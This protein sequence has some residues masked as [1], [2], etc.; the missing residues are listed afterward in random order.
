MDFEKMRGR[1]N[2]KYPGY[3]A[4]VNASI[5][6]KRRQLQEFNTDVHW[7][8]A[9]G[10]YNVTTRTMGAM[11]CRIVSK[12]VLDVNDGHAFIRVAN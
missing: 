7:V 2:A 12:N 10:G 6:K 5:E 1:L 9:A 4:A 3:Q 8:K 11:P